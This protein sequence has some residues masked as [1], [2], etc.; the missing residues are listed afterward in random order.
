MAGPRDLHGM[1]VDELEKL[2][3]D[4]TA[5]R[6]RK[7]AE[8]I[9]E[10]EKNLAQLKAKQAGPADDTPAKARRAV[11]QFKYWI[12]S[13]RK[14]WTGRGGKKAEEAFRAHFEPG[15]DLKDYRVRPGNEAPE[16][17]DADRY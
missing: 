12:A 6:D 17:T 11:P 9:A 10:L 7:L 15:K 5:V 8:Q 4:A 16:R 13:K 2:I 14:G 1:T 3:A